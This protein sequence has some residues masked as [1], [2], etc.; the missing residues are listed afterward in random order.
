MGINSGKPYSAL[1]RLNVLVVDDESSIRK[2]LAY[3]L[4][5]LGHTV[6]AVS[7]AEEGLAEARDKA[8]DLAFVDM[9]LDSDNGLDLVPALLEASPWIKCVVITAYASVDTAVEAMRRGAFDYLP[10]PFEPDQVRLECEK[11]LRI[12]SLELKLEEFKSALAALS[13]GINLMTG[14]SAMKHALETARQ[15]APTESIVLLRGETG[16]GK[17][18]LARAIHGW[19]RRAGKPMTIISCP[20]LPSELLESE[21]F[22]H[23]RGAFTGAFKD[24]AGRIAACHGGTLFLDEIGDLPPPIQPK[25]L[26]FI[27][28]REY[29]RIG[30]NITRTEDVRIIAATN[31]DLEQAM[32]EGRF[33]EDLFYRLNV[34]QIEIPPLR[35]RP[36][37]IEPLALDFLSFCGRVNHKRFTGF[38]SEA[39]AALRHYP[40]PG[41]IR[42]LS[43]IIERAAILCKHELVR[44]EDLPGSFRPQS[45]KLRI[46]D[47]VPLEQI[48]EA[49]IRSVLARTRKIQDAAEILGIDQATLYRF[50]KTHGL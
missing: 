30:E 41:N 38:D 2:T 7:G 6:T 17:S 13:P 43:N 14:N 11:V 21:L 20:T 46:G 24:H 49:H 39:L 31:T 45:P 44:L 23:A 26:R 8:F 12:R 34:I 32:R 18:V 48:E 25:L 50:R 35:E 3:C 22:G 5:S 40:W 10:K 15:V 47:R 4:E 28:D 9:R 16:T 37:D 19:S 42:E 29:E 33:R 36:E 27:Q 1:L